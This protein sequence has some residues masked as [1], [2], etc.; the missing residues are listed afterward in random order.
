M[1]Q[2]S[3]SYMT[4]GKTIA[5]TLPTF[6]GRMFLLFNTLSRFVLPRSRKPLFYHCPC[7]GIWDCPTNPQK[8]WSTYILSSVY[9]LDVSSSLLLTSV[10]WG[11][12]SLENDDNNKIGSSICTVLYCI[13]SAFITFLSHH[14]F[15]VP[16]RDIR[17]RLVA[18]SPF[19]IFIFSSPFFNI[20]GTGSESMSCHSD[21]T[22]RDSERFSH[23]FVHGCPPWIP[24]RVQLPGSKAGQE[25]KCLRVNRGVSHLFSCP[26]LLPGS[27]TRAGIQLWTASVVS[28]PSSPL[29]HPQLVSP[30]T[31]LPSRRPSSLGKG[32]HKSGVRPERPAV[33][34]PTP[35]PPATGCSALSGNLH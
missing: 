17:S 34:T 24:A 21:D 18:S 10:K 11:G 7:L 6:I 30:T 4:T 13:P 35:Q 15:M 22:K 26:A 1:V 32:L 31:A 5:L 9:T 19:F 3:P 29:G 12:Y 2:L 14:F 25:N 8:I 28:S 16:L 20:C 23:S 33:P 27:C